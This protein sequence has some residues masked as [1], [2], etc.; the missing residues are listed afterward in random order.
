MWRE[1]QTEATTDGQGGG[2]GSVNPVGHRGGAQ[3]H[4]EPKGGVCRNVAL[5]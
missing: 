3:Q 5:A 1:Q 2:P 4:V